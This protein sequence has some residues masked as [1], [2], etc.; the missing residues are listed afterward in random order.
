MKGSLNKDAERIVGFDADSLDW[1]EERQMQTL[2]T[3][4]LKGR[5]VLLSGVRLTR[6]SVHWVPG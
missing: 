4:L 6:A 3:C 5:H 2:E 1:R